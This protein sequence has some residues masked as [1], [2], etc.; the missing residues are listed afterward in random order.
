MEYQKIFNNVLRKVNNVHRKFNHVP[1]PV[2]KGLSSE[3][4]PAEFRFIWKVLLKREAAEILERSP[5]PH[6]VRALYFV[7][8]NIL[9]PPMFCQHQYFFDA[10]ILSVL[11]F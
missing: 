2:F 6:P 8:A 11:R 7:D 3:M 5:I 10:N 4:D 1:V 9:L